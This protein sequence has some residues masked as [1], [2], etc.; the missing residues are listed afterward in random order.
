MTRQDIARALADKFKIRV[1]LEQVK[2]GAKLPC[3]FVEYLGSRTNKIAFI[4]Y[5]RTYSY[6]IS[7]Y[8]KGDKLNEELEQI[9]KQLD[10]LRDINGCEVINTDI[11]VVDGVLHY[12]IDVIESVDVAPSEHSNN[13]TYML[14][15]EELKK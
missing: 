12:F 5:S 1:E 9:A 10:E 8:P 7:Y 13:K 14:I 15:M 2:Q 4:E 6:D 3:F 11:D